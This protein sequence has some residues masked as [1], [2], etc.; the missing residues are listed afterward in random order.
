MSHSSRAHSVSAHHSPVVRQGPATA[1]TP[2][3]TPRASTRAGRRRGVID[4]RAASGG[5]KRRKDR[6]TAVLAALA[7]TRPASNSTS[8]RSRHASGRCVFNS[9]GEPTL[10]APVNARSL[11]SSVCNGAGSGAG[12]VKSP[13][14]VT[15]GGVGCNSTATVVMARLGLWASRSSWTC[16]RMTIG[17]RTGTGKAM[18]ISWNGV[19]TPRK[20]LTAK[21]CDASRFT[22]S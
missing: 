5:R 21:P 2:P 12:R 4:T 1:T 10:S 14:C 7:A 18:P 20:W 19:N 22:M 11:A 3:T 17:S 13:C 9:S 8:W 6:R 15:R 16:L